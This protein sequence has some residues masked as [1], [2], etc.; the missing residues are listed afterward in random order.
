MVLGGQGADYPSGA[1]PFGEKRKAVCE[2]KHFDAYSV[3]NGRNKV[4]D[5]F[6]ISLRDLVDYYFVPLKS[7]IDLADV[8]AF[9]CSCELAARRPPLPGSFAADP[10]VCD[11]SCLLR[12]GR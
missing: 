12:I 5:T 8:G 1:Y 10:S 2:M 9:M 4:S 7:C 11:W 3:E 6:D